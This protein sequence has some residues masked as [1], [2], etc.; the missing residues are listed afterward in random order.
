MA[1]EKCLAYCCVYVK[2]K[3]DTEGPC[4]VRKNKYVLN[5]T[6][7]TMQG[8]RNREWSENLSHYEN[9]IFLSNPDTVVFWFLE[10]RE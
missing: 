1:A 6:H 8:K 4:I 10:K 2:F 7:H 9:T 5:K 3:G